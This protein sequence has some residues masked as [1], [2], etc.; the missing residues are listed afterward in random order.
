M[1]EIKLNKRISDLEDSNNQFRN[2]F[3]FATGSSGVIGKGLIDLQT[4]ISS[5]EQRIAILE[6]AKQVKK[7]NN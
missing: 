7:Q 6:N 5:L 4:K 1:S 3:R 2:N